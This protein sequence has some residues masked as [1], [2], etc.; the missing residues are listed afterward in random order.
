M[1]I[2]IPYPVIGFDEYGDLYFAINTLTLI[3]WT[4][5]KTKD[6]EKT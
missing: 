5:D 4:K 3:F 2:I 6:N 1:T